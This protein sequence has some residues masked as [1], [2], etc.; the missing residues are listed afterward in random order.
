[1]LGG[2]LTA[3]S[4]GAFVKVMIRENFMKFSITYK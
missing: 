1:M 2:P 3:Y 4:Y